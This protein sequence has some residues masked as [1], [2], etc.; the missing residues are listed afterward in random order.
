MVGRQAGNT[1]DKTDPKFLG[2]K[3]K[4]SGM[5][6]AFIRISRLYT[7]EEKNGKSEDTGIEAIQNKIYQYLFKNK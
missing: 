3:T 7:I 1:E 2:V 6:N 4:M 5:K